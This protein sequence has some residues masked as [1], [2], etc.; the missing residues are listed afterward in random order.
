MGLQKYRSDKETIQDDGAKI[1]HT[2]WLGG[3]SLSKVENCRITSLHGEPRA[4]VYVQ[5]EPDTFFSIPAKFYLFGKVVTGYL[6]SEDGNHAS[7]L[8][9]RPR[10]P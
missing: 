6:T 8:H 7:N 10:Y 1:W 9:D 5:G 2:K 3:P 4:T